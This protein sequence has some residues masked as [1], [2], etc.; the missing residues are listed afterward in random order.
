AETRETSTGRWPPSASHTPVDGTGEPSDG[1]GLTRHP[2]DARATSAARAA[3]GAR[4][5]TVATTVASHSSSVRSTQARWAVARLGAMAIAQ[6]ARA[7]RGAS[8]HRDSAK[9]SMGLPL[10]GRFRGAAARP[11]GPDC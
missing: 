10:H 5:L 8:L 11:P 6:R 2:G 1:P 9:I 7:G 4:D 3:S